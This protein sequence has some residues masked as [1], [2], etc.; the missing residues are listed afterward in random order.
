MIRLTQL[1]ISLSIAGLV[2]AA[3]SG[4]EG[5]RLVTTEPA[6]YVPGEKIDPSIWLLDNQL[7]RVRLIDILKP[8]TRV[9][10]L[11]F[12][13]GAAAD[14]PD[15]EARGPLWCEDSFDDLAV[16]R[17]AYHE[18]L[19]NPSVQFIPVAVAPVYHAERFGFGDD[20]FLSRPDHSPEYI[21][22]VRSFVDLTEAARAT[23]LLPFEAIYYDPKHRLA[24]NRKERELGEGF[25][26][27]YPWQG[28]FKWHGDP[29]RYGTPT[30]WFLGPDG[31]VLHSP[32]VGNDYD[33]ESP[34]IN[35]GYRELKQIIEQLLE[36]R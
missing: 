26:E 13:G 23:T 21:Q 7:Q 6:S 28:Q 34:E 9:A 20:V 3:A 10:L 4:Q 22:A 19:D 17:A 14:F 1:L 16:Q 32:L 36:T 18:F 30:I 33:A 27:I 12:F 35:Y 2:A 11:I 8:D 5:P 15:A 31:K 29:R 25:G 24:Q